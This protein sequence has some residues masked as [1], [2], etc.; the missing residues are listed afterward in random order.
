M[1][2]TRYTKGGK[3]EDLIGIPSVPK[4]MNLV[5]DVTYSSTANL[6]RGMSISRFVVLG[7]VTSG[8]R[9]VFYGTEGV[10]TKSSTNLDILHEKIQITYLTISMLR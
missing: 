3:L 2:C 5:L 1:V 7:C 8:T 4:K 9:L 10:K 6:D